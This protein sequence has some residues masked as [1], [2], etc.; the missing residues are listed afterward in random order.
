MSSLAGQVLE[1]LGE[2]Y[3]EVVKPQE[4]KPSEDPL[5]KVRKMLAKAGYSVGPNGELTRR[6]MQRIGKESVEIEKIITNAILWVTAEITRDDGLTTTKRFII[7]GRLAGG[8]PLPEMPVAADQFSSMNWIVKSWGLAVNIEP[9]MGNRDFARHALQVTAQGIKSKTVYS[10]LGWRFIGGSW[11]YLHAGMNGE[12]EVD[13]TEEG[14]SRY[15]L[16]APKP[17]SM[18]TAVELLDVGPREITYPLTALVFLAPLCEPLRMAGIEPAFVL[19]LVGLT[20]CMKSTTAALFL[21]FFGQFDSRSLPGN[22]RDTANSLE[23][24]AFACKDSLFV[25]DDFHPSATE[26]ET[27]AMQQSA[28]KLLRAFGDRQGRARLNSDTTL[29]TAFIPRGLAVVT[30]EDLPDVGQSGAAR[31]FALEL[32]RNDINKEKLTILQGKTDE[33]SAA[34]TAYVDWLGPQIDRLGKSFRQAFEQLRTAATTDGHGRIPETVAWLQIGFESFAAFAV[35]S[36]AWTQETASEKS[37]ECWRIL[38]KLAEQQSR[39]IAE[40]RPAQKFL[41]AL[42]DMLDAKIC[43]TRHAS[44]MDSTKEGFFLG[45]EE[46]ENFL[47]IP[48]ETFK[49]VQKF[50]QAQG[51][52]FPISEKR[53]WAHLAAENLIETWTDGKHLRTTV[54][55]RI[56]GDVKRVLVLRKSALEIK[57]ST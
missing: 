41:D 22:F 6:V 10:H 36:G 12:I 5:G 25:I 30:G 55:R 49:Q 44:C 39:T 52:R 8:R 56:G 18:A 45:W 27:R 13:V 11:V 38:V 23:K 31:Y 40:D 9:G 34:M 29:K 16:P 53:L 50:A 26:A 51:G 54:T 21:S 14:L 3:L 33:L 24:R 57:E 35:E 7:A 42:R 1:E 28:Q 20:G 48:G 47:L 37:K 43:W 32:K 4:E 15:C 17:E 19:W 2:S 46:S